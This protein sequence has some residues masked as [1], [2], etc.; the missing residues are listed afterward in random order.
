MPD[1]IVEVLTDATPPE[2]VVLKGTTKLAI[3]SMNVTSSVHLVEEDLLITG[4]GDEV[5]P[6][7]EYTAAIRNLDPQL[8]QSATD[9]D[10]EVDLFANGSLVEDY[11]PANWGKAITSG[12]ASASLGGANGDVLTATTTLGEVVVTFTYNVAGSEAEGTVATAAVEVVAT[13]TFNVVI[14]NLPSNVIQGQSYTLAA[15]RRDGVTGEVVDGNPANFA[16]SLIAGGSFA[17]ITNG[18]QLNINPSTSGNSITV[19]ATHNAFGESGTAGANIIVQPT[20][21]AVLSLAGD[22]QVFSN[23]GNTLSWGAGW[24][25][26]TGWT[27]DPTRITVV[28]DVASKFGNAIQKNGK[29]GDV[30]SW[31]QALN[32]NQLGSLAAFREYYFRFVFL[33]SANWQ[34]HT[35]GDKILWWG[36]RFPGGQATQFY[37]HVQSGLYRFTAQNTLNGAGTPVN[38]NVV[39]RGVPSL[40]K[41]V[42]HTVEVRHRL[43]IPGQG[44]GYL[45]MAVDG[46]EATNYSSNVSGT[47][48]P[49]V[50]TP[51]SGGLLNVEWVNSNWTPLSLNGTQQFLFWGGSGDEKTVNDYWRLSELFIA[52]RN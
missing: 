52:G 44:D 3:T 18:N 20:F 42:Y 6:V 49:A 32:V 46:V 39:A 24:S 12:G 10:I 16:F 21:P 26:S 27:S 11:D 37:I 8:V 31:L 23:Q 13:P 14:T 1:L 7:I 48:P 29:I 35:S 47:N 25:P 28:A 41:G 19:Q 33:M 22:T 2:M 43:N 45:R 17:S 40:T 5:I 15:E 38:F 50:G 36:R 9:S 4:L 34:H 30:G 51:T